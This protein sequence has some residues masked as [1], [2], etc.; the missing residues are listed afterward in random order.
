MI[1]LCL[2]D[3]VYPRTTAKVISDYRPINKV[4]QLGIE[5]GILQFQD[6]HEAHYATESIML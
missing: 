6:N 2:Y 1:L 4:S 5:H 3:S